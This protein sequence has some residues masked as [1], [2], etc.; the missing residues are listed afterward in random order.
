MRVFSGAVLLGFFTG[1]GN[2]KT[3]FA[4]PVCP[5]VMVDGGMSA[6]F[7]KDHTGAI[8]AYARCGLAS[9]DI[10]GVFLDACP[11]SGQTQ[12]LVASVKSICGAGS[13]APKIDDSYKGS[14]GV[15]QSSSVAREQPKPASARVPAKPV[16]D[17]PPSPPRINRPVPDTTT[18]TTT[19]TTPEETTTET[20]F[21]A[22]FD[23]SL[24]Y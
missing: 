18:T 6:N 15:A 10:P 9:K 14:S 21:G 20:I 12:Q 1:C 4:A 19:T 23:D 24:F 8:L 3:K 16:E 2:N 5:A 22:H 11:S 17:A 13:S 7:Y